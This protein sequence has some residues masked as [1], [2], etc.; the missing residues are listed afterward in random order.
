MHA[1]NALCS[2][3]MEVNREK[4][5]GLV[6]QAFAMFPKG[7]QWVRVSQLQ[8]SA[9]TSADNSLCTYFSAAKQISDHH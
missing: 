5:Q 9:T 2:W 4:S 7:T 6:V 1:H 8:D 3:K